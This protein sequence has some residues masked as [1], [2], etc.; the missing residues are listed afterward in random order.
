MQKER[1][2]YIDN[3]RLLMIVFV[4]MM[5]LAVTYSGLGNWY[6]KEGV[7]IGVVSMAVFGYCQSFTQ[8]YFMGLLFLIAGY[9]AP[10]AYDRKGF[11]R[12][13]LDRFVR[14]GIP[15]LIYMLAIQPFILYV[16][17]GGH[18]AAPSIG[19]L[20]Y[21][22]E[23]IGSFSF[24]GGNGPLWFALALL[25]FCF[26]YAL[27][28]LVLPKRRQAVREAR[29]TTAGAVCLILSIAVL[30]FLIRLV[31]PIGTSVMNMQLGYFAQYIVL[32][33]VG[34]LACRHG[35]FTRIEYEKSRRWLRL[36]MG[37]GVIV[38]LGIMLLGGVLN[39]N[40]N[41]NGGLSWQA[42]AFALWE[43]F[44]AVAMC[45]GLIGLFREKYNNQPQWAK[46]LSDNAFAVYVFH[47]PIVIAAAQLFAPVSLSPAAKFIML[48]ILAIPLCF[49]TAHLL[50]RRIPLLKKVM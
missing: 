20:S 29:V 4:V 15:A 18:G 17:L 44:T 33:V 22:A 10:G 7:P 19:F 40:Q 2:A 21:Y 14:L 49:V 37:P 35:L 45:I 50:I 36:A 32:F 3:L 28:R 16:L 38:W 8:G 30:A 47:P 23:Y 31:Q 43:S 1:L 12:F 9:F 34:V 48:C 39:G 46:T 11:G 41:Y 26:C 42:A 13:L 27:A 6:Y 25:A 5:H 24:L